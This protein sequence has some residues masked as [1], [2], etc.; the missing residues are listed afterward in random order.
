MSIWQTKKWQ[1]MLKKSAQVLDFFEIENIF[2]EKRSI[3]LWEHG[4]FITWL[5]ILSLS[6]SLENKLINLCK[7]SK[8]LFIQIE[9]INYTL[10]QKENKLRSS[11]FKPWYYKKFINHYTAVIDLNLS[12]DEILY[13]M[14]PKW[15]YNIRLAE[16][17][18]VQCKL[19]E[20]TDENVKK[21]YDLILETTKRDN[22]FWN[23][24]NYYKIFLQE[25]D[26]SELILALKNNKVISGGIFIF[27]KEISIYYYWSSSN[28]YRN[29]MSSYLLQWTAIK[30]AKK[31]W[32]KLYD[33]LWV[34]KPWDKS[35]SLAWVTEFK[36]KLTKDIRHVSEGY[37]WINK[38]FKYRLI[39][40]LRKIKNI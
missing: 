11:L 9:N 38:N 31:V 29:L 34:T 6:F 12:E 22:F 25:L 26:N 39:N 2:V 19:V 3:G 27:N 10:S 13:N 23:S 4:L 7:K 24:F 20:K 35:S 15:R 21:F 14:K 30:Y 40:F 8:C 36:K 33:F 1:E 32:I 18:W 28:K 5:D 17:K 37:I 16:K